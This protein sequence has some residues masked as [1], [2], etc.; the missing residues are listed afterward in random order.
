[1]TRNLMLINAS[2]PEEYR[3]A[4]V[5]DGI[6]DGFHIETIGSENRVGNIYLGIVEKIEPGLQAFFVNFGVGKNGFLSAGEVHPDYYQGEPEKGLPLDKIL[7]KGDTVLVQVIKEM[8]GKKGDQLTTYI[9]LAGRY[10]VLSPGNPTKG[11]SKKIQDEKERQRL[12]EMVSS[13]PIPEGFGVIVRTAAH[14]VGK[15]ELI[16][17]LQRLLRLWESI[18][19]KAMRSQPMTLIHREQDFLLRTLRDHFTPDIQEI[20]IDDKESYQRVKAYMEVISP[21]KRGIVR[22]HKDDVPIFERYGIES[23]IEAIFKREVQLPSGGSIVIEPTEGLITIDVNS[24]KGKGTKGVEDTAFK[25]NMEAAREIL[26]QLRLRDIGGLIVVDFIDMKNAKHIREVEKAV[27]EEAKK[28]RAKINLGS[29]SKFGILELSRERLGPQIESLT[30]E[31]CVLCQGRG[32]IP[33]VESAAINALRQ[34]R[35]KLRSKGLMGIE[36]QLNPKVADYLQNAKR[37][38][39]ADLED[40]YGLSI[41]I[42]SNSALKPGEILLNTIEESTISQ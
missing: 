42:G 31:P 26:R 13:L 15:R 29:I 24:G 18:R 38:K 40:K 2:D 19:E 22:L 12:K 9:S 27:K 41:L 16:K 10:L 39:L 8:P 21:K 33:S 35:S 4:I 23:Q 28:D 17:D 32:L 36:V 30:Y 37:R 14:G 5:R 11:V 1:M 25:T 34:I 6:L 20:V 7:K 3:I